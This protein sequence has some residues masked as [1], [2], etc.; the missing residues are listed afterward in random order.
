MPAVD[1]LRRPRRAVAVLVTVLTLA[2]GGSVAEAQSMPRDV[3]PD[4]AAADVLQ[5]AR[6]QLGEP[7]AWG[8]SGP[9]SW[10]CSGLTS[11]WRSVG[12]AT[13]LPRVSAA[14]QSWAVPL[15]EEQ[16][17]QGDLVFFGHP[18]THVGLVVGGGR[19]IDASA[20]R[21]QVVERAIWRSGVVRYGRVRRP[22]MPAVA[23]WTPPPLPAAAPTGVVADAPV[24]LERTARARPAAP[25]S[26]VAARTT[27]T[28]RTVKAAKPVRAVA[29]V[30]RAKPVKAVRAV[31]AVKAAKPVRAVQPAAARPRTGSALVPLAGLPRTQARPSSRLALRAAAHARAARGATTWTDVSLVRDAWRRAGGGVL[32]ADRAALVARG[33][34]VRLSDARVGDLVVYNSPAT[35]LGMHLGG[36][37]M[38]DASATIGR[39]VVRKVYAT[40]S[41]RLVRLG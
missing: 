34:P 19:M 12:G 17:R 13:G 22:G 20:S 18:V 11:L 37:L 28:T 21:G 14:Q 4:S 33:R 25:T 9:D 24:A 5:A 41:V 7:Y 35:H 40:P 29:P 2:S 27:R 30:K 1:H 23:P 36:G 6:A 39:V 15:P 8:G 32:P 31:K 26:A 16:A 38:V 3:A 10:D